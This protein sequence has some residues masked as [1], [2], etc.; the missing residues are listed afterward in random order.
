MNWLFDM[1]DLSD[2]LR[3]GWLAVRNV[4]GWP[5]LVMGGALA[6]I[7]YALVPAILYFDVLATYDW[8]EKA[9]VYLMPT[10]EATGLAAYAGYTVVAL[11]L[12]PTL[13]ELFTARFAQAG[14]RFAGWLVFSFCLFDA[15]TDYPRVAEFT[16]AYRPAFDALPGLVGWFAFWAL[17][18]GLLIM[19]SFGFEALFIVFAVCA[20]IL[21]MNSGRRIIHP[22]TAREAREG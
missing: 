21:F 5:A 2:N 4:Y 8:T 13:V 16:N 22:E 3:R 6:V 12:L 9:A 18:M 1:L 19:A 10:Y 15:I 20:V 11:T 7:C 17:R 14:I